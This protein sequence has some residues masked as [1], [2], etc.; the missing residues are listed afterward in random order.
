MS[1]LLGGSAQVDYVY[2][3]TTAAGKVE[4][5]HYDQND[6]NFYA[7]RIDAGFQGWIGYRY[8]KLLLQVSYGLGLRDMS[9]SYN[10]RVGS[11]PFYNS[12]YYNRAFHVSLAY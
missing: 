5:A 10:P 8:D 9:P 7:R 4:V 3:Q 6:G 1:I 11:G 2:T 12:L